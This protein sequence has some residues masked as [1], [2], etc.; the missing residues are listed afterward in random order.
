M[1]STSLAL[2]KATTPEP[3]WKQLPKILIAIGAVSGLIGIAAPSLRQQF[4]HSYFLAFIYFLSFC[5]GGL[6]L[7]LLHHLFDANW[8]VATRRLTEHL[9]WLLPVMFA[10]FIPVFILAPMKVTVDGKTLPM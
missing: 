9:A 6:F 10:M 2:P 8:S 4:A 7:T 5:L 1:E 3:K